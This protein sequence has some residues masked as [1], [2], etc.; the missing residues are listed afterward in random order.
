MKQVFEPSIE[1]QK[2]STKKIIESQ[3]STKNNILEA[4]V[5]TNTIDSSILPH[6]LI[7]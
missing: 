5:K 7:S 4:L 6:Y 1:E 2:E 3:E